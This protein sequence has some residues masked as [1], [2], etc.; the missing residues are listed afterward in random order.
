VEVRGFSEHIVE[1][2]VCSSNQVQQHE[3]FLS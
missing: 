3:G 1:G 2:G